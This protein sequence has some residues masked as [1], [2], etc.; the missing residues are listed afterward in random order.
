MSPR[1]TF[2]W[3]PVLVALAL[4]TASAAAAAPN[5]ISPPTP[6]KVTPPATEPLEWLTASPGSFD[7]KPN[8][9]CVVDCPDGQQVTCTGVRCGGTAGVGCWAE[10]ARGLRAAIL[11]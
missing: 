1:A 7:G 8:Q 3:L 2:K 10:D 9:T 5:T 11:C 6:A 4:C